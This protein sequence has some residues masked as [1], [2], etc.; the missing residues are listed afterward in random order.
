VY[1]RGR[2]EKRRVRDGKKKKIET[3]K[4]S[5]IIHITKE[6]TLLFVI[7]IAKTIDVPILSPTRRD[8]EIFL[9]VNRIE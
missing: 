9:R 7:V 4:S 5:E 2:G 8:F 1:E 6:G 3:N